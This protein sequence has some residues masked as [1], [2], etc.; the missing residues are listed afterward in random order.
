MMSEG[1][2]SKQP[3]PS[4]VCLVRAFGN[5]PAAV[6]QAWTD[7]AWVRRWF[8]SDPAGIVLSAELDVRTGGGF[9]VSF[10][11]SD[12]TVHTCSGVYAEV[13]PQERLAFSRR[14][15]SEPGVES[16]VSVSLAPQDG[17]TELRF[18]HARLGGA[19]LHDYEQGWA[20]TFAKL[21][22]ALAGR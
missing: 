3:H 12:G 16:F 17:G 13:R 4:S 9:A 14:W 8:G 11:D 20:R 1:A 15:Q 7:P 21:E 22:R 6:W 18:E 10:R 19:S 5:P 2:E